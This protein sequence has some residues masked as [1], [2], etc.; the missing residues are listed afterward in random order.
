L[1]A[2]RP[3]WAL[4]GPLELERVE[5]HI[6]EEN[7]ASRRIAE[8]VGFAYEGVLRSYLFAKGRRWDVAI[9]GRLRERR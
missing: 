2:V 7:A 1:G 3:D 8:R 5:L 4:S 6:D 9:Y